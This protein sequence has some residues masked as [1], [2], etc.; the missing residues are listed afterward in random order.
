MTRILISGVSGRMG[1]ALVRLA[2][3]YDTEVVCG[4]DPRGG[5]YPFPVY[6]SFEDVREEIDAIVDFSSPDALSGLLKYATEHRTPSVICSTGFSDE[7]KKAIQE[8]ARVIPVFQSANMSLGVAVIRKLANM[9]SRMLGE[10]FDVEIVE[11]HHNQKAD[12]PSGTALMLFDSVKEAYASERVRRDGRSGKSKREHNEIGMHA[13]RGGTVAGEHAVCYFGP[14]ER[15]EI[16]HSAEDRSVFAAG[17]LR[18]ACYVCGRT[19]G[20]YT[21]EDMLET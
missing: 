1:H 11:A 19:P 7:Q 21:M 12:A 10:G 15:I 8:A 17:A 3:E 20:L 16:R 14:M 2:P 13:L 9:A 4:V 6:P 5:E 18:A